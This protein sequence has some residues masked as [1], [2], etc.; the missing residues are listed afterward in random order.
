VLDAA[1]GDARMA[2]PTW[3]W[4][5]GVGLSPWTAPPSVAEAARD[6]EGLLD[7]VEHVFPARIFYTDAC[8][9]ARTLELAADYTD[10]VERAAHRHTLVALSGGD[11]DG[12]E[13]TGADE[14]GGG[15][16]APEDIEE[17]QRAALVVLWVQRGLEVARR[18]LVA[19]RPLPGVLD[20]EPGAASLARVA[21]RA[22]ARL[23]EWG[24]ARVRDASAEAGGGTALG[25]TFWSDYV[26]D[27]LSSW[28]ARPSDGRA[29]ALGLNIASG[30]AS[31]A[32]WTE[33]WQRTHGV[34]E[35]RYWFRDATGRPPAPL[36]PLAYERPDDLAAHVLAAAGVGGPRADWWA[37][38]AGTAERCVMVLR[39]VD[40][41]FISDPQA[42][43]P[44]RAHCVVPAKAV[45]SRAAD[46][47]G[48]TEHMPLVVVLPWWQ[49]VV[50]AHDGGGGVAYD[51]TAGGAL[52]P[53]EAMWMAVALWLALVHTRHGSAV[54]APSGAAFN[55]RALCERFC[56]GSAAAT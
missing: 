6:I 46:V 40:L 55:L 7:A 18:F 38:A 27:L 2:E 35:V 8:G 29:F 45:F 23:L 17:S 49:P 54:C 9:C 52:A 11:D 39:L 21:Q 30:C 13:S 3:R 32:K 48:G 51:A 56:E 4:A 53:D 26:G 19:A 22:H 16:P 24:R 33:V 44:W 25:D 42:L 34:N 36:D 15:E 50:L 1:P 43:F 14:D 20:A 12:S 31:G 28:R 41:L 47:V 5:C 10:F 37:T